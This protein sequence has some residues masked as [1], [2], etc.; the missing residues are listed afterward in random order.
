MKAEGLLPH[1]CKNC[2]NYYF[3]LCFEPRSLVCSSCEKRINLT[4]AG[5][6]YV[7][8]YAR[9]L[10]NTKYKISRFEMAQIAAPSMVY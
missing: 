3:E 10:Q 9:R 4:A 5:Y 1:K 7:F 8:Y 6:D 2:G